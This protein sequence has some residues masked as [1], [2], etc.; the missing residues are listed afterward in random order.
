MQIIEG[1][2]Q[3]T[4]EWHALRCGVVTASN[5]S[6]VLAKGK[7]KTRMAYMMEI[8]AEIITGLPVES[9][10]NASM[11][12]GTEH[13]PQARANYELES[14]NSVK[15]VTFITGVMG[16]GCSPD[17]LVNENGMFESK[18]PK[19]VTQIDYFL[20]NKLPS[21]YKAQVQ[22]QLW[23]AERDWCDFV[24]FDPRI[25]GPSGYFKTRVFR[26]DDYIGDLAKKT[27]IFLDELN[28][29]LTKLEN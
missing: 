7:D 2:E 4:E 10:S 24:S 19:T 29:L 23:V 22:G 27:D 11:R 1:I 26:D 15:Q 5:F 14:G 20:K 16:V 13:E 17:G 25:N 9:F 3:G 21:T 12:W 8:A 6:K 18:C 28:E